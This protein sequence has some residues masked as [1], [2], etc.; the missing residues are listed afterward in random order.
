MTDILL[1]L[2]AEHSIQWT[3]LKLLELSCAWM[4]TTGQFGLQCYQ[5]ICN[6]P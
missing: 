3:R 1:I 6:R 2:I 5:H 4:N